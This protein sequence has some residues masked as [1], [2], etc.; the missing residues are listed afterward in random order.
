VGKE[1]RQDLTEEAKKILFGQRAR[2]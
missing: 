1:L 2:A